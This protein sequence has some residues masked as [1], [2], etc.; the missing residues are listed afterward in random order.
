MNFSIK[1]QVL[2]VGGLAGAGL[3]QDN[4]FVE[5]VDNDF[6]IHRLLAFPE[7]TSVEVEKFRQI[8][9]TQT[10]TSGYFLQDIRPD[11]QAEQRCR[12][13]HAQH[14]DGVVAANNTAECTF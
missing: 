5:L 13:A 14:L 9:R 11:E 4:K 8:F 12:F 1:R 6:T 2:Q 10:R 7:G 3:A